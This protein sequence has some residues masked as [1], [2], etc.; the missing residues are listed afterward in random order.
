MKSE[1]KVFVVEGEAREVEIINKIKEI[2]FQ[3]KNFEIIT[4]PAGQNIYMLWKKMNVDHFETD[5]IEVLRESDEKIR[6]DLKGYSRSDFSEVYLFF[7]YDAHQKNLSK[8]NNED[9]KDVMTKMLQSFDNETEN[10]KL[11]ISYP[12]VEAL[13]DFSDEG[14]QDKKEWFYKTSDNS[15]YK[16]FSARRKRNLNVREYSFDIWKLIM[17]EFI[18][19]ISFLYGLEETLINY[20]DYTGNISPKFIYGKEKEFQ[21]QVLIISAFPEFLLDYFSEKLWK[22]CLH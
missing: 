15:T 14:L 8:E 13:R 11:Y 22:K 10:G 7:D 3:H 5:L 17:R 19:K 4:L 21:D 16:K 12:M 1:C 20:K 2:F 9:I 18:E 6:R